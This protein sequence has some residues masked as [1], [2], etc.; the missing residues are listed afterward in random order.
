MP[1]CS[2]PPPQLPKQTDTEVPT[3]QLQPAPCEFLAPSLHFS[4]CLESVVLQSFCTL[5]KPI[6]ILAPGHHA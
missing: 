6:S 2:M 3:H 1:F 5:A 4:R